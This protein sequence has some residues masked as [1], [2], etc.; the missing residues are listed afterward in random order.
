VKTAVESGVVRGPRMQISITMLSQTGGHGDA[1]V[2]S[3]TCLAWPGDLPGNPPSVVDGPEAMRQRVRQLVREGADVIKVATSGGVLSPRSKPQHGHFRDDELS[4][5]VAEATSAGIYVMAHAQATE[6]IKAAVRNGIRSIEHG[7]YL[8]DEAISMMLDRGT[9]LVPTLSAP[10]AVLAAAEAGTRLPEA[11][12]RKVNEVFEA[13]TSSFRRAVEAGV[14]VAMGTD[15]GVGAHG[16]NLEEINLM[17]ANSPMTP[18]QAW[19][20]TTSSAA[21][22]C[23]VDDRL[24]TIA[25]GKLADLTV[26]DGDPADLEGLSGRVWGAWKEGLRLV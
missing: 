23:G 3:G 10:R 21:A 26:I 8:D 2:P 15:S 18:W 22:L 20:A 7:V 6:G 16:R 14:K 4:V 11:V 12:W 1:M 25:P 5:L 17:V 13:H 9:W 19:A 24:G